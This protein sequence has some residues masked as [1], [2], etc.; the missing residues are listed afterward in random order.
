MAHRLPKIGDWY[1]QTDENELLKVLDTNL[2]RETVTVQHLDGRLN[3]IDLDEWYGMPLEGIDPPDAEL[4]ADA[5]GDDELDLDELEGID[6]REL[7][8]EEEGFSGLDDD[9]DEYD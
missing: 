6:E 8:L 3:E 2:E 7:S 5:D 9:P 1:E 4:E